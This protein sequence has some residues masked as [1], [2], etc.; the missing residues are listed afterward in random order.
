MSFSFSIIVPYFNNSKT[1]DKTIKSIKN[2]NYENFEVIFVDDGSAQSEFDYLEKATK[3]IKNKQVLKIAHSGLSSARNH[4][5]K[6]SK[7]DYILFLDSDDEIN[8]N[9]LSKLNKFLIKNQDADVIRFF[10]QR[11]NADG[12]ITEILD[13]PFCKNEQGEE[14]MIKLFTTDSDKVLGFVWLLAIK[15]DFILN[16]DISFEEGVYHEDYLFFFKYML[17]AQHFYTFDFIGYRYFQ[18]PHGIIRRNDYELKRKKSFNMLSN[19][20]YLIDYY[21]KISKNNSFKQVAEKYFSYCAY[22]KIKYLNKVD[23]KEFLNELK[24]NNINY[25]KYV[26]FENYG[27]SI[28]K[29]L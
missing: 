18:N 4:G 1:V 29:F 21:K 3:K 17:L 8:E 9:L 11:I 2:Q 13:F 26:G 5:I 12:D 20:V 14:V 7:N 19:S 6:E 22:R 15:N 27:H 23:T 25:R 24:K 16:N 10:G 28:S